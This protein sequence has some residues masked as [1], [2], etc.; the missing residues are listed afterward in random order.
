MPVQPLPQDKDWGVVSAERDGEQLHL[1]VVGA[2][3]PDARPVPAR[4]TDSVS[5]PI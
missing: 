1:R 2:A 3:P 5:V 4:L